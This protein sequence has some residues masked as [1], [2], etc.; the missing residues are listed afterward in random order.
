MNLIIFYFWRIVHKHQLLTLLHPQNYLTK[1]Q[2]WYLISVLIH[3]ILLVLYHCS[4]YIQII[5]QVLTLY[6]HRDILANYTSLTTKK[7]YFYPFFH[8]R[9]KLYRIWSYLYIRILRNFKLNLTIYLPLVGYRYR[10]CHFLIYLY[11]TKIHK[12]IKSYKSGRRESAHWN[13]NLK[14]LWNDQNLVIKRFLEICRKKNR[15]FDR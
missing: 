8:L 13:F 1:I 11:K 14:I 2:I 7:W 9:K 6:L 10:L 15:R 4:I 12:R 5:D 3:Q